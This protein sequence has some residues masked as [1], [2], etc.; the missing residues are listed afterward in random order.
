M[1]RISIIALM[2]SLASAAT[3]AG[4]VM[5]EVSQIRSLLLRAI[6]APDGQAQAWVIGDIAQ[7][8]KLETKAPPATRVK[9]VVTTVQQ[10]RPGCKRLRLELSTPT[11]SMRTLDGSLEPFRMFYELNLC[12]DGQPPQASAVG[13]GVPR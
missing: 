12:R 2:A 7:K 9:A 3:Q 4:T 8:I 11:H 13:K 5:S 6:D 10:I 1:M